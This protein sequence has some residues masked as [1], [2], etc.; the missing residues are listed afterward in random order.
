[1]RDAGFKIGKKMFVQIHDGKI[2]VEQHQNDQKLQ[3]PDKSYIKGNSHYDKNGYQ[4]YKVNLKLERDDKY[5]PVYLSQPY[6]VYNFL[7]SLQYE[8]REKVLSLMLDN[9]NKLVGVYE[10]SK[11]GIDSASLS[12]Y[13][14]FQ[15]A[16]L[17]NSKRLILAHN[18]P[19]GDSEPSRQD[20][21]ITD[22]LKKAADLNNV[23]LLDHIVIGYDQYTSLKEKGLL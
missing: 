19:S 8:P 2:E 9:K 6:Q 15:P 7:K 3:D 20:I 23:Q 21:D 11:G 1:M 4:G 22:R 18:H 13:E 12:P 17:A 5:M 14:V 10:S 16:Y